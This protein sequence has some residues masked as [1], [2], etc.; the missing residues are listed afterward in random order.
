M[1]WPPCCIGTTARPTRSRCSLVALSCCVPEAH[2]GP[3]FTMLAQKVV[4]P[5]KK[6]RND[7]AAC[8]GLKS[9]AAE[10]PVATGRVLAQQGVPVLL[11]GLPPQ[12][13]VSRSHRA[14]PR[15][16]RSPPQLVRTSAGPLFV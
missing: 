7:D 8:I 9:V 5:R 11:K 6:G 13:C 3:L 1:T 16:T 12:V 4:Q 14:R 10:V 15:R 2:A